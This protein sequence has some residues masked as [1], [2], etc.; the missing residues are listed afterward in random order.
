MSLGP[1]WRSPP[2]RLPCAQ[3]FWAAP[4]ATSPGARGLVDEAARAQASLG[5]ARLFL[6][7][8]QASIPERGFSSPN[9]QAQVRLRLASPS[10][11][12]FQNFLF[13]FTPA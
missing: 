1:G 6:L 8:R 2:L 11:T 12:S 9:S 13:A 10:R 3:S 4:P 7:P 5:K